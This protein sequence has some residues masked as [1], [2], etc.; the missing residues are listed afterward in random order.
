MEGE[1]REARGKGQ[2]C[3][4]GPRRLPF[5]FASC[6]LPLAFCLPPASA[7]G[8]VRQRSGT[9]AWLHAVYFVDGRRGWAVGGKGA[10]LTTADGGAS[11]TQ[12][13][14]PPTDDAL[15]D[16]FFIDE[17]NGWM[18]CEREWFRLKTERDRRSYFLKT[19]DG[20]RTW[21]RVEAPGA[22]GRLAG[23][24]FADA[25]HGWAFGEMGALY[26]TT[27]GGR[28]W[29]RQRVPSRHLLLGAFFLDARQGWLVGA[30]A[31]ALY[32]S[33]GGAT[34][35]EGSVPA[36]GARLNAV[37]FADARRGWAVG[38][39]GLVLATDDG[40]RTWRA[41]TSGV[42]A[43]LRDVK[44]LDAREGWAVGAAGTVLHT[45]DG[46]ATWRAEPPL[47]PHTLERLFFAG[48]TRGWAVGFG[49]TIIAFS[50]KP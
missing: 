32:T 20:G 23:L 27:D 41:Q 5:I 12:A 17:L 49:G 33:D 45:T 39:G 1:R 19:G 10:L 40:G 46:G 3:G 42:A 11:W 4:R 22:D 8:W 50:E 38:A 29:A 44:F 14:P 47:T 37:T 28:T 34:W 21:A 13:T 31:T 36:S 35:H 30:G 16:L 15:R 6:L 24:R 7:A 25:A 26:A 43:D 2:K 9:F 18:V 48:R